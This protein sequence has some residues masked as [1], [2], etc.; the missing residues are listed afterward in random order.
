MYKLKSHVATHWQVDSPIFDKILPH[1]WLVKVRPEVGIM[2]S[3]VL[4]FHVIVSLVC[5]R[6]M[7]TSAVGQLQECSQRNDKQLRIE[8]PIAT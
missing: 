5:T 2:Q 1:L 8:L 7:T 4:W 3:I 6:H